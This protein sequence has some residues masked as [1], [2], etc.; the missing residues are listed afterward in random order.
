MPNKQYGVFAL[1]PITRGELIAV[2]GGAVCDWDTFQTLSER[3]RILSIQVEENLFLVPEHIGQ[4]DYFN[5]S[6]DPNAGLSGQIGLV[7]MRDIAPGEEI[8]FDYAM[9]D[10]TS[11]DE[12][13]CQCGAPNCRKRFTGSDWQIKELQAKY[14]GHFS[15]YLQRRIDLAKA[16]SGVRKKAQAYAGLATSPAVAMKQR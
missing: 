12:F 13:D 2:F 4:G 8:C 14:A 1:E 6:C 10:S 7:A 15:P 3:S 9:S 11:Y 16:G 5:H